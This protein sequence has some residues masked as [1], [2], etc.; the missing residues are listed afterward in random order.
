M[1]YTDNQALSFINSQEKLSHR[2]MKWVES[3][4]A[5]TFSIK[6]KKG[7]AN[8]VADTLSRRV[9]TISEIQLESIG[10]SVM[11]NMYV[12][13]EDFKEIYKA[14]TEPGERYHVDFSDFLIQDGLLFKGWQLCIPKFSMRTNIIKEKHSRA[15]ACHFGLDKTLE[16]VRRH[17][18]WPKL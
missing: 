3:L 13:D 7:V 5:Y 17:Y 18:F 1:V 2:H 16:L 9:L 15:M 4:Q 14:C 10:I 6:H 11:K 8:K 12:V